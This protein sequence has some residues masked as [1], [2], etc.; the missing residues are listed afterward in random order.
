MTKQKKEYDTG[1]WMVVHRKGSMKRTNIRNKL[2]TNSDTN[3]SN[4]LT[5]LPSQVEALANTTQQIKII[6][7]EK[8]KRLRW[9]LP[10]HGNDRKNGKIRRKQ[11]KDKTQ[12]RYA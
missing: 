5:L 11:V 4:Y 2:E 8:G 7:K 12:Q 9:K 3:H 10:L 6:D 1:S